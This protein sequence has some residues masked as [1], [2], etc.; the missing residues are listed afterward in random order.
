MRGELH[1]TGTAST[2]FVYAHDRR[3]CTPARGLGAAFDSEV[4]AGFLPLGPILPEENRAPFAVRARH[5]P[6][7][8]LTISC[9]LRAK[10]DQIIQG[11]P[12]KAAGWR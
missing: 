2:G 11:G 12:S 7:P 5:T 4:F 8:C 6:L 3:G 9:V 1:P 10:K